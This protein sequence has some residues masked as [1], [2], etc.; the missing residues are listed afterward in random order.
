MKKIKTKF[1]SVLCIVLTMFTFVTECYVNTSTK[2]VYAD[3]NDNRALDLAIAEGKNRT[4]ISD[5]AT[6]N[7]GN[8][9]INNNSMRNIALYL[10]N[11][12]QPF[13]T[14]LTD[15]SD[16]G[17][18]NKTAD[19]KEAKKKNEK[20][21]Q[22]STDAINAL[23]KYVGVDEEVAQILIKNTLKQSL[24]TCQ[25]LYMTRASA[26]K[27]LNVNANKGGST[28][29]ARQSNNGKWYIGYGGLSRTWLQIKKNYIFDN[30]SGN[31]YIKGNYD[32]T[33]FWRLD[34][35][36]PVSNCVED[37]VKDHDVSDYINSLNPVTVGGKEFVEMNY[38]LYLT[39][40]SYTANHSSSD[41][42]S[43]V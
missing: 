32:T 17:V 20:L 21:S 1:V 2:K 22:F 12:Y 31:D 33:L 9:I 37:Y 30:K 41:R 28:F 11:F 23:T 42:K 19:D 16:I 40:I 14:T 7:D 5:L 4:E 34:K 10:S 29:N 25:H 27:L 13:V 3:S 18:S 15:G 24:D 35:D 43:V 39:A 38:F 36:V 26:E 6:G 8:G